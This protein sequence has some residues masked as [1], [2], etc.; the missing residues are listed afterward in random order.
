MEGWEVGGL[1]DGRKRRKV[2][3]RQV[4]KKVC[5]WKKENSTEYENGGKRKEYGNVG[6]GSRR[7]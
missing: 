6:E 2:R 7:V 3:K 1:K 4:S 5:K